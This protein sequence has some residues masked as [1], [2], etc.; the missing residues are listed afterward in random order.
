M[1]QSIDPCVVMLSE[2]VSPGGEPYVEYYATDGDRWRMYGS[3]N[4]CGECEWQNAA[5]LDPCIIF[6]GI[7][8]GKPGACFNIEGENRLDVPCRPELK[9]DCPNCTLRG[10][11]L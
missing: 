1:R 8:I 3:C 6:T 9:N 11:Y 5:N 2:G 10:E 4:G 7:D